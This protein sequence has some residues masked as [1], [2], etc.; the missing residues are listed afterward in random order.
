MLG[1]FAFLRTTTFKLALLYAVMFA[2]FAAALLVYLYVSTVITLR[3]EANDRIE[4]EMAA[5][6]AAYNT[7]GLERL[8][9][10]VIE[11]ASAPGS[12]FFYLLQ[13]NEGRKISGDLSAV[14]PGAPNDPREPIFFEY[15]VR[16]FSGEIETRR[17]EGRVA[18][19]GQGG[20]LLVAFDIG[21]RDQIVQRITL[22]VYTAGL[23]GLLLSLIGG[24]AISRSAARRADA[25]ADTAEAVMGGDLSQRAPVRG[26]G[27][28]F[29]RLA[30][31]LN[32]MLERIERLM[33]AA[34]HSGDAIAHDLR[35]PL[36]RLRNRLEL[37][38]KE[39]LTPQK[40]EE[41]LGGTLEDVD[42]V[43]ATCNAILRLSRLDAGAEGRLSRTD[44]SEVASEMAEFFEPACEEADLTFSAQITRGLH[45]LCDRDLISQ[46]LANLLDNA[47]KYTPEGGAIRLE[48]RRDGGGRVVLA[49]TDT[50]PGIP[51]HMRGKVVERF[52]RLD[53]ARTQPGSGLGLA[54]VD[55]VAE[56][57]NG[58]LDLLN[59]DGPPKR[60]GL[61]AVLRLPRAV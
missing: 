30:E 43:L 11:R 49:V 56:L 50:G 41:T 61:K 18:N 25:L 9:Q 29:D 1:R 31:R 5:L 8:N 35:S 47:V 45:V 44:I 34:R 20:V 14:P 36:S 13:D 12:Q 37:T 38:L 55:A 59:G 58:V 28:E 27:D 26:S 10:S 54:L 60:P 33:N 32:A 2:V 42:R 17:A 48:A 40:A 6:A 3:T 19:L 7:G 51:G 53:S 46:A 23:I 15:D 24:V 22:A 21:Q 16:Q 4:S 57:H 39:P 52:E